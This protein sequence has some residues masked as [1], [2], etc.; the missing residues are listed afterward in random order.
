TRLFDAVV[1]GEGEGAVRE[2]LNRIGTGEID[3]D[4]PGLGERSVPGTVSTT[5]GGDL[6]DGSTPPLLVDIDS[7]ALP[8]FDGL[9]LDLYSFE[10]TL[11]IV[12]SRGCT[13]KCTF[14]FETVMWTRFRSRSVDSVLLEIRT[15]LAQYGAP[16]TFRFNDSLLNGDLDWLAHFA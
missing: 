1:V 14:C 10:R 9:P 5:P 2:I 8:S 6:L 12:A 3:L 11:P 13:A 16:L 15:R 4:R 7:I